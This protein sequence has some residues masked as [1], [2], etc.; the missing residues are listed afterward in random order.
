MHICL[1]PH[2][3]HPTHHHHRR[4][5]HHLHHRRRRHRHRHPDD[6]QHHVQIHVLQNTL[7]ASITGCKR[8]N[9]SRHA[10][11]GH[12]R[13]TRRQAGG[14]PPRKQNFTAHFCL[15]LMRKAW[16]ENRRRRRR[17]RRREASILPPRCLR[18]ASH[19]I[20]TIIR[21][22]YSSQPCAVAGLP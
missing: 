13:S 9:L 2:S 1:H 22:A 10:W 19:D 8:N 21:E 3:A 15:Q 18:E 4:H 17:R 7:C 20:P 14:A 16:D 11:P 5:H 6:H 12:R